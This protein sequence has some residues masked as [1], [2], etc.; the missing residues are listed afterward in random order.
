MKI[1][2]P[3]FWFRLRD[4]DYVAHAFPAEEHHEQTVNAEADAAGGRHVV[5]ERDEKILVQ[6][7]LFAADLMSQRDAL[8]DGIV[9]LGVAQ[10]KFSDR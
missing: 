10:S 3:L 1:C 4:Q 2:Q 8:R 5:F 6:L 7:L 9:L